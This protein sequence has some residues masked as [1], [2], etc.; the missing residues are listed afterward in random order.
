MADEHSIELTTGSKKHK[1]VPYGTGAVSLEFVKYHVYKKR[2]S[3]VI[4]SATKPWAS[5]VVIAP[6]KDGSY[7][8]FV[9]YRLLNA[10]T[11]LDS[12]PLHRMN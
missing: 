10:I 6:N 8:C 1:K 9:N 5:P 3:A 11:V 2:K 4:D 12:Y 7:R